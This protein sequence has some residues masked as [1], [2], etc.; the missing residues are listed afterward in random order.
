MNEE[1]ERLL[2]ETHDL[3]SIA[4]MEAGGGLEILDVRR[5]L[6]DVEDRLASAVRDAHDEVGRVAALVEVNASAI[7]RVQERIDDIAGTVEAIQSELPV[8]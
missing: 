6:E 8:D 5:E 3:A 1:L 4:A 7:Q 2:R